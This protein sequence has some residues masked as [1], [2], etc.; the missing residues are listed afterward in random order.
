MVIEGA[1][2]SLVNVTVC[3]AVPTFPQA[4]VTVHDFVTVLVQPLPLS[5]P[6]VPVATNPVLQLSLTDADPNAFAMS[7]AVGLHG[8]AVD[9]LRV[10]T[11]FTLSVTL[12]VCAHVPV[13]PPA[14]VVTKL[15]V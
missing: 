11:G 4:S 3:D 10:M 12:Y 7:V 8:T 9:A 13:Q 14:A 5:A 15:R 6:T 2:V 1:C